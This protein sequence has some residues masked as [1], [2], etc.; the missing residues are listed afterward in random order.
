MTRLFQALALAATCAALIPLPAH[1]QSSTDGLI[2]IYFECWTQAPINAPSPG[3]VIL[4]YGY[5]YAGTEPL[6]TFIRENFFVPVPNRRNQPFLLQPGDHRYNFAETVS[7]SDDFLATWIMR[8]AQLPI[9]RS[10]LTGANRCDANHVCWDLNQSGVCDLATEDTNG[11]GACTALDCR[12]LPGPRGVTGAQGPVG[13]QGATGPAGPKGNAALSPQLRLATASSTTAIATVA[14]AANEVLIT[15]GG[16]CMIPN[17]TDARLAGSAPDGVNAWKATCSA[18]R[19]T[20]YAV[21]N[22]K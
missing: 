19:A 5:R 6:Q 11:D 7:L 13:P 8:Q 12:G 15:G 3:T 1:G 4:Y 10:G 14:C 17:G 22:A 16:S 21:C 20:V 18:G 2:T 9:F